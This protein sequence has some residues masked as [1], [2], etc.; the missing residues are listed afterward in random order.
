MKASDGVVQLMRDLRTDSFGYRLLQDL[1]EAQFL[2]ALK[3]EADTLQ[4]IATKIEA[5]CSQFELRRARR[6]ELMRLLLKG[7]PRPTMQ[8]LL[9][10]LPP[11]AATALAGLWAEVEQLLRICQELNLR[12]CRLITEQHELMQRLLGQEEV[13]YAES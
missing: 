7:E 11:A 13:T 5:L 10:S 12:N 8:A 4:R 2:G 9:A 3:H 6:M 1:L